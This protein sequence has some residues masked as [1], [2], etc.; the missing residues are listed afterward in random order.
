MGRAIRSYFTG[1]NHRLVSTAIPNALF[2]SE[3]SEF[4]NFVTCARL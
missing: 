4:N 3:F 2:E 1:I